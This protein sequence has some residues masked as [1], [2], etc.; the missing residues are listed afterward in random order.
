MKLI[1]KKYNKNAVQRGFTL[2]ELLVAIAI[3]AVLSG[4]GWKIFDYLNRTK[5]RNTEHEVRLSDVQDA[6]LQMQRDSVQIV[7][8]PLRI[9]QDQHA[10]LLLDSGELS[11]SKAGVSDPLQQGIAPY[12]RVQYQ[13]QAQ[14]K[15]LYRLSYAG[16]NLAANA[17]PY[18]SV[19]LS[20]VEQVSIEVMNPEPLT[21]WPNV[22]STPVVNSNAT[23]SAINRQNEQL[24]LLP[25][26]FRVTFNY[27]D[28]QYQW[29][30]GLIN[31]DYL[32]QNQDEK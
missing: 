13:Y 26:G 24:K 18:A 19:L 29:L 1:E 7:P 17:Q 27:H 14:E 15:K 16:L 2:V 3:F 21:Q 22:T 31:T 30:F 4:L 20:D 32:K 23:D 9:G 6:F 12:E 5:L 25:R 10:A 28:V 11:F 8:M